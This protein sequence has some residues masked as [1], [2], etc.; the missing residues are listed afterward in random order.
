MLPLPSEPK[1]IKQEGNKAVFEIEGLYPG[2]GITLGNSLRRVLLSSLVGS[3]ITQVKIEGVAH[4]FST[5]PGVYED[6]V[7]IILNLKQLRFKLH[8]DEPQK[9]YLK[10]KG[11]KEVKGGD[12]EC[13]SQLEVINKDH[14]IAT[15]TSKSASLNLEVLVEKGIGYQPVEL[16]KKEKKE[17][18][19]IYVD[20][21]FTPVRKVAYKIENMRVGE[22]TDFDRLFIEIETDGSITPQEALAQACSILIDH[23]DLIKREFESKEEENKT[24]EEK[25]EAEE[26]ILR[27][28]IEEL[29]LSTRTINAL[30]SNRIRTLGGLIRKDKESL[31]AIEGI[32]E[33]AIEEI[34]KAIKKYGLKIKE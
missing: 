34:N 3:S 15:L 11:E 9:A 7:N 5:I 18:G 2:Y 26:D 28:P 6:V 27:I 30:T 19:V 17:I 24:K 32:G 16:R 13:P 10:V 33:K 4:E 1:L 21:I 14:H 25:T 8:G 20:A 22:R 12:F 31:M 29:N 23:F